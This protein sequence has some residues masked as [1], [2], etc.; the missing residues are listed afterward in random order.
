MDQVPIAQP[1]S[2]EAEAAAAVAAVR[3]RASQI[4]RMCVEVGMGDIASGLI[5]DPTATV[6]SVQAM[7]ARYPKVTPRETKPSEATEARNSE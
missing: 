5:E 7:L 1:I 6:E 3:R 2:P 4:V